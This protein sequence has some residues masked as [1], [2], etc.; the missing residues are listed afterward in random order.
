MIIIFTFFDILADEV[1]E[2]R[3]TFCNGAKRTLPFRNFWANT[4]MNG[5]LQRRI[6]H[7]AAEIVKFFAD[8]DVFPTQISILLTALRV[9]EIWNQSV[10]I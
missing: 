5:N 1:N 9:T 8:E 10:A 4:S 2:C 7:R 6:V 3:R